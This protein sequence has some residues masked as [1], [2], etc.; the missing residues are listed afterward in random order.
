MIPSRIIADIHHRR[1]IRLRGN[2]YTRG[3]TYF[4]T[5]CSHNRECLF[6]V[7]VNGAVQLNKWGQIVWEEWMRTESVRPNVQLDTF[8]VM[9]NHFHGIVV[10][11]DWV[12]ARRCL[13]LGKR[14]THRV[15]PTRGIYPN[16]LGSII[17]QFKSNVTRRINLSRDTP[18]MRVW[19]RN[20]YEHVI[21]NENNLLKIRQYIEGNPSQWKNDE[22]HPE[23]IPVS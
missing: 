16:S 11:T 1:S 7:M 17:G 8:I 21:R 6:G 12:G 20:Y 19:Q 22:N 9:P 23:N 5:V 18:G 2:D 15:A 13:A 14:A 4:V 3:G 10:I